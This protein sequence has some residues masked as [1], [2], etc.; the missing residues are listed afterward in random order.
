MKST[1][2]TLAFPFT[3]DEHGVI[4]GVFL[5]RKNRPKWQAGKLNG[6]GGHVES[7]E[8]F[9][10][11][12]TREVFEEAGIVPAASYEWYL[13]MTFPDAQVS[14]FYALL[15]KTERK[16]VRSKTDEQVEWIAL[17]DIHA[18][19]HEMIDNIPWMIYAA[20]NGI[21]SQWKPYIQAV[22]SRE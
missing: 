15:T 20:L 6:I 17:A 9:Y 14:V 10:E 1:E 22:Y 5:I 4:D 8:S 12:C 21:E 16:A 18:L 13:T 19:R 3:K 7:G 11:C 2:Y